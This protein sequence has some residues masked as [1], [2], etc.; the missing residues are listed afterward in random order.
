MVMYESDGSTLNLNYG[1]T[2]PGV[3][4]VIRDILE[5]PIDHDIKASSRK[6][7][8]LD[9]TTLTVSAKLRKKALEEVVEAVTLKGFKKIEKAK[10]LSFS[11]P[12]VETSEQA[13]LMR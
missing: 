12:A 7:V 10:V 1:E 6:R 13:S 8:S 9:E 3:A 2:V 5:A 4:E 11:T